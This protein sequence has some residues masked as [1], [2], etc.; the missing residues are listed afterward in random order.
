[1]VEVVTWERPSKFFGRCPRSDVAKKMWCF[2]VAGSYQDDWA[3]EVRS[4]NQSNAYQLVLDLQTSR[5]PHI[6]SVAKPSPWFYS[7]IFMKSLYIYIHTYTHFMMIFVVPQCF[8]WIS[9]AWILARTLFFESQTAVPQVWLPSGF[10]R[11]CQYAMY[12]S[13][14][15]RD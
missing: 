1:M 8:F 11:L 2:W 12:I 14:W 15:R 5:L 10:A 3:L 7:Q 9:Q 13:F 6:F 4:S